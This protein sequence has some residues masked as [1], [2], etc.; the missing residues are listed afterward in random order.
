MD[1]LAF[2]LV[3]H[4]S[5]VLNDRCLTDPVKLQVPDFVNLLYFVPDQVESD[6]VD[7]YQFGLAGL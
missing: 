5:F 1:L 3:G 2:D 4:L 6:F 7:Q